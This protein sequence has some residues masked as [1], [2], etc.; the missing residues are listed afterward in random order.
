MNDLR[1]DALAWWRAKPLTEKLEIAKRYFPMHDFIF[2][3]TSTSRITQIYID[4]LGKG[5]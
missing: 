1:K 5:K 2:V 3:S 4:H